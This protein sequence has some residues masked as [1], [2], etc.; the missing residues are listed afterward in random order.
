MFIPVGSVVRGQYSKKMRLQLAT[1]ANSGARPGLGDRGPHHESTPAHG[2][3]SAK[4][5]EAEA[6][7]P[8]QSGTPGNQGLP[9]GQFLGNR[10]ELFD[11]IPQARKILID[12]PTQAV[13][14]VAGQSRIFV[15]DFF[16]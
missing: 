2:R 15:D 4:P 8:L 7:F 1:R 11:R 5:A 16:E 9:T 12:V 10:G 13:G 3:K 14:D 6:S